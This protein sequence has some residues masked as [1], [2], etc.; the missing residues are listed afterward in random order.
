M[1]DDVA[2]AQEPEIA[3]EHE[4]E[5]DAIAE[6]AGDLDV[7]LELNEVSM[8][9]SRETTERVLPEAPKADPAPPLIPPVPTALEI[10]RRALGRTIR[11]SGSQ[12]R[13]AIDD[14]FG[15]RAWPNPSRSRQSE[16][17]RSGFPISHDYFRASE[18]TRF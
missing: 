12:R 16:K 1:L 14:S 6:G 3:L 11:Q 2:V 13:F 4:A 7:E 8:E 5:G 10:S 15:P 9:E 18:I 17:A